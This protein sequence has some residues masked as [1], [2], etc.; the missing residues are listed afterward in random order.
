MTRLEAYLMFYQQ[1]RE[2]R[3]E[4]EHLL[5]IGAVVILDRFIASAISHGVAGGLPTY[6]KDLEAVFPKPDLTIYLEVGIN[7]IFH[8]GGFGADR[9]ETIFYQ[10]LVSDVFP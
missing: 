10:Q 9:F 8:R 6:C 7:D 4:I 2:T 3:E 5:R 1:R